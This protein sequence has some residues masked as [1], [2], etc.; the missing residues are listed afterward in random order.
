M[1]DQ[2]WRG[3]ERNLS[4]PPHTPSHTTPYHPLSSY[5]PPLPLLT[6]AV[7]Q[8]TTS[9]S[10]PLIPHTH[11]L[12]PHTHPLTTLSPP[13][14]HPTS[15]LSSGAVIQA[16]TPTDLMECILLLEFYLNKAW[17]TSPQS[18]LLSALPNPQFAV[19]CATLSA[20]GKNNTYFLKY[21]NVFLNTGCFV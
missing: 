19:R 2:T 17:L 13:L 8:A 3:N 9:L 1:L 16:T 21:Y 11:P 12:I 15:F 14:S 18:R 10:H 6:G 4:P 7:I 20:G 5:P